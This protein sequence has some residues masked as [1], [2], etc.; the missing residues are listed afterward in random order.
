MTAGMAVRAYSGTGGSVLV[1][2]RMRR[3][4]RP[5]ESAWVFGWQST[6]FHVVVGETSWRLMGDWPAGAFGASL[7]SS[8]MYLQGLG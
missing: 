6:F 7:G 3:R 1:M 8:S 2:E 4:R 5:V